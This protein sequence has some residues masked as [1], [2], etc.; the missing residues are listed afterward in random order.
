MG[1]GGGH[2]LCM[3]YKQSPFCRCLQMYP[4][5]S[6]GSALHFLMCAAMLFLFHIQVLH[7]QTTNNVLGSVTLIQSAWSTSNEFFR[8]CIY[9]KTADLDTLTVQYKQY[10]YNLN[11]S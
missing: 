5:T 1:G 8:R 10:S 2:L 9:T 7:V 3:S 4:A 11:D 6:V